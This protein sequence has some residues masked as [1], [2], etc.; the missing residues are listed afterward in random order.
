ML[1]TEFSLRILFKKFFF[2]LVLLFIYVF[3][4]FSFFLLFKNY[5]QIYGVGV[6]FLLLLMLFSFLKP[7][8]SLLMCISS[9]PLYY[10]LKVEVGVPTFTI[11][12][13]VVMILSVVFVVDVFF[14]RI[15]FKMYAFDYLVVLWVLVNVFSLFHNLYDPIRAFNDFRYRFAVPVALYFLIRAY[16]NN[17]SNLSTFLFVQFL[18]ISIMAFLG[19]AEFFQTTERIKTLIQATLAGSLFFSWA[20]LLALFLMQ[21]A[22]RLRRTFLLISLAINT[23]ALL[24]TF[25]RVV[26]FSLFF[27]ITFFKSLSK[28]F[29]LKKSIIVCLLVLLSVGLPFLVVPLSKNYFNSQ[30]Y[31]KSLLH[32]KNNSSKSYGSIEKSSQRLF[33]KEFYLFS[34]V[35]RG[36]NWAVM[37]EI[38]KKN[39]L[40]GAG[41][42]IFIYLNDKGMIRLYHAHNIA[43]DI[44]LRTGVVGLI[45]FVVMLVFYVNTCDKVSLTLNNKCKF[46]LDICF[47]ELLLI[48][49][50]GI[51]NNIVTIFTCSLFWSVI[52]LSMSLIDFSAYECGIKPAE[53]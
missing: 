28:R 31:K 2:L 29:F 33:E 23:L 53:G 47:L 52:G 16:V 13:V 3:L 4:F 30:I 43:L 42:S 51:T 46:F 1:I 21:D 8:W 12:D 40:F 32:S 22:S 38:L 45:S 15:E 18:T 7:Y 44:L 39:F 37:L 17:Y 19:V 36:L 24:F 48:L 49:L 14:R 5:E 6:I 11:Y 50:N 26:L 10:Y 27:L 41:Y 35:E 34:M 9:M 25:S 20:I